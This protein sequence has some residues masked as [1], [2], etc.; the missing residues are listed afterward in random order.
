MAHRDI[1]KSARNLVRVRSRV[2][3][4]HELVDV[5]VFFPNKEGDDYIGTRKG[6]S[7]A[8]D[9]VPDLIDALKWAVSQ[10]CVEEEDEPERLAI[11]GTNL[12]ELAAGIETVL[13][14]HGTPLHWDSIER[15]ILDQP[16]LKRFTKWDVRYA[17][18][19]NPKRFVHRGAGVFYVA[20]VREM[21]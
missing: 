7:L 6:V 8:P 10:P 12:Q 5:R 4:G 20:S 16:D 15:M 18:V 19:E 11:S 3:E 9:L 17:L 1:E 14:E 13:D 2:Y 21:A